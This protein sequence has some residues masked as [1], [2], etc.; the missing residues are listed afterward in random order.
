MNNTFNLIRKERAFQDYRIIQPWEIELYSDSSR[1]GYLVRSKN[2]Q[3]EEVSRIR[4][5]NYSYAWEILFRIQKRI[6]SLCKLHHVQLS[7]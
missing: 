3:G 1:G 7:K 6:E 2:P 5:N 4:T